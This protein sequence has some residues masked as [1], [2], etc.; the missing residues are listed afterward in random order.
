MLLSNLRSLPLGSAYES[1]L[2]FPIGIAALEIHDVD[3]KAYVLSR[4][5]LLESRFQ[6]DHFR[7]FR[8]K[9]S[10]CWEGGETRFG[11]QQ[12]ACDAILLG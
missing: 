9:L 4:L 7:K 2:L 10:A 1:S 12:F 6:L 5:Q 3:D 8:E 11:Q